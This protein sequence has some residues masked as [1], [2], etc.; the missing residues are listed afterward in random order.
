MQGGLLWRHIE[1]AAGRRTA[2]RASWAFG[3]KC[4]SN[5]VRAAANFLQTSQTR[6]H[7]VACVIRHVATN[8]SGELRWWP[9]W[10]A[11]NIS[12]S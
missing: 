10:G 12:W 9:T 8:F 6:Q 11:V 1:L 5:E 4:R 2:W 3:P 7:G